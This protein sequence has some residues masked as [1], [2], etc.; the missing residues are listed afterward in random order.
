MSVNEKSL[1]LEGSRK[2]FTQ[3]GERIYSELWKITW[4]IYH[5]ASK[6]RV[7]LIGGRWASLQRC[8]TRKCKLVQEKVQDPVR[9]VPRVWKVKFWRKWRYLFSIA[10]ATNYHPLTDLTQHKFSILLLW[11]S[12]VQSQFHWAKVTV[13]AGLVPSKGCEGRSYFLFQ[14]LE[15]AFLPWLSTPSCYHSNLPLLLS[16]T[17]SDPSASLL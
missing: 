15:V 8:K 14:L 2:A 5:K 12:E 7:W 4:T 13:S 17:N 1:L 10:A 16:H 3:I 11:R 6:G 9:E